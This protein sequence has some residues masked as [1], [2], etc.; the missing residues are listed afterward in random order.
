MSFARLRWRGQGLRE[1]AVPRAHEGWAG[2]GNAGTHGPRP[3]TRTQ[4]WGLVVSWAQRTWKRHRIPP[5]G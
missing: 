5:R 1:E 2:S 4:I 3:P